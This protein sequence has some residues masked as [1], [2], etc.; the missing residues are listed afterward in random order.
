[1]QLAGTTGKFQSMRRNLLHALVFCLLAS[2]APMARAAEVLPLSYS[3]R[4][5]NESGAPLVGPVDLSVSFWSAGTNGTRLGPNLI[6]SAVKLNQGV[7]TVALELSPAEITAVFGNGSEPVFVEVSAAGKTY[8][9]QEFH[10]VPF[11][12][13]VPTDNSLSFDANGQLGLALKSNAGPNQFLTRGAN[14]QFSWASPSL[15]TLSA[16]AA[17]GA[18]ASLGQ[19]LTFDGAKWV[20][21]SPGVAGFGAGE[22]VVVTNAGGTSTIS[23]A[24]IGTSGTYTKVTTNRYGQI[25]AGATLTAADI[26]T[27]D[28]AKIGTGLLGRANGG[29]GVNSTATFPTSGVIVTEDASQTLTNKSLTAASLTAAIITSGTVAGHSLITGATNITT[30]GSIGAASATLGG[31]LTLNGNGTNA[32]RLVLG[33]KGT[34]NFVAL[35]S[36]DTLSSSVVWTLPPADG[37]AGQV[38]S[39]DGS[40]ALGWTSGLAPT[41]AAG[42]DLVG[43][44]PNPT[45]AATGVT[46]GT[47]AKVVTDTKGR[48]TAGLPLA[49]AD[50]PTLPA[51]IIGSGVFG[52]D[53]GGTGATTFTSNGVMLGNGNGNLIS[54]A[55]GNAYQILSV[56]AGGGIPSFAALNLAQSAAVTGL[57][58]TTNGG[59]GVNSTA[60]FPT[61]G[62][63][64]TQTAAETLTN[65]TLTSPVVNAGTISGNS[66][67]TGATSI[68]TAGTVT[69][70]ANTV[71]GNLTVQGDGTLANKILLNDKGTTN[72]VALKAADTLSASTVWTLPSTDGTSGQV[73]MTNGSGGLG[74][75]SGLA[76]TGAA[77]GDLVG[78]FPNPTLAATGV[79]AGTYAK[80]VTDTKGRITAGLPLAVADVPTLPASIIG[81][82]V[83][84]VDKGGTGATTFTSN[85]VML[86]NGTGN[87][88]STAAGNAYQILSVPAGGGVPSFA[89]LNLAQS[90]AVTGLL[91]T[92]NGGTGV[93]STATFPTSGVV[94][95]ETAGETLTNKT[96]TS[97]VINAGTISGASLITGTA[98]IDTTGTVT[99]SAATVKGNITVVGNST[100]AN[101]LVL[102]DRGSA[103]FVALK[104]PDTLGASTTWTLPSTDGTNGQLLSTNGSGV[105]SWV[106]GAAPTGSAGGDLVGNFPNPTLAATGVT[107]GTYAKVV[108]D[109]KGRITAGLPLTAADIPSLPASS[110]GSGVIGV[111]NGGTGVSTTPTNGQILI[112]NGS[113]YALGTITAGT[114]INVTNS[115]GV[116]TIASTID[117]TKV[118][119]TGD[120]MTGSL[121][122]S[123]GPII[124]TYVAGTTTTIDWKGGNIQSTNAAAGAI[125]FVANSMVDGANYTLA[126][127]N[128]TGGNYTFASTGLTFY[129]NPACPV[130]VTPGSDTLVTLIK[131]GTKV[132]ASWVKD[133]SAAT[134]GGSVGIN[135]NIAITGTLTTTGNVG[136]GSSTPA[137]KLD[138]NGTIKGGGV[139]AGMWQSAPT[140]NITIQTAAVTKVPDSTVSFTL[141]RPATIYAHYSMNASPGSNPGADYVST[142]INID[143]VYYQGSGSH[144]HPYCS[145]D[146]NI[147]L[148]GSA[149]ANLSAGAHTAD[150]YWWCASCGVMWYS[151]PG[152]T[153]GSPA[154]PIG[155]RTLTVM[156]FY[157]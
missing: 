83:F 127:T 154:T 108:T 57:L 34:A 38:L 50:V 118:N 88:I 7:F 29:T 119:K 2:L 91:A 58:A 55:A 47:Y 36:A 99:T 111:A 11:A 70:S 123:G 33:D 10:L 90:A 81:S 63:I 14:G 130:V 1:M 56:P 20:A 120:T 103:N 44:F 142:I 52:V 41:G 132:Y 62:V 6:L 23:L 35:K 150:I 28:A 39:T 149:V 59:T 77:G 121:T 95:T 24:E 110:I 53:K 30:T 104:S 46:A 148:S 73:L 117:T 134:S 136:I 105:M 89:A 12:L 146:C 144:F 128:A 75:T 122:V 69:S 22:G 109:T 96:L 92:T 125:T 133:F 76:P 84:G 16:D 9:R 93:S 126:L 94:V 21:A 98:S 151:S 155:G 140:T 141:D 106:S 43:N 71:R 113:G 156:A 78:N 42:G 60:T 153:S 124:G 66:L 74:W 37:S 137:A 116:V 129:C 27:L 25:T 86:G 79:T 32:S 4:L 51:S 115:A 15:A 54:T 64:V 48:I 40:G 61:S 131:A 152:W 82:G 68:D 72:F 112:G 85:G 5:T 139:L 80:V 107:A 17:S 31:N 67:I 135:D 138:V 8:P 18:P 147:Q 157:Q 143:G 3:G 45:L 19:V 26:P 13:R 102:N 49:V 101:K 114:G 65:K 87:L 97:P 100:T 145:G